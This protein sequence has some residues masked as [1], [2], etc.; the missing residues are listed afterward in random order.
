MFGSLR[1][2]SRPSLMEE[3]GSEAQAGLEGRFRLNRQGTRSDGLI[4][5]TGRAGLLIA[6]AVILGA[7]HHR[8]GVVFLLFR[9]V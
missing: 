6:F 7:G 4:G 3:K 9:D 1:V 8:V 2:Q 5:V